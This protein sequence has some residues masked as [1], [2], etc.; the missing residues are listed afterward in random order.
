MTIFYLLRPKVNDKIRTD[1]TADIKIAKKSVLR[2]TKAANSI[3][4]GGFHAC[5]KDYILLLS[6]L[7]E[8]DGNV[9]VGEVG[10]QRKAVVVGDITR[11][12]KLHLR[13]LA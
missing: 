7:R 2:T 5:G 8:A 13:H 3:G 9:V 10:R 1:K 6:G 11:N 12:G 4:N